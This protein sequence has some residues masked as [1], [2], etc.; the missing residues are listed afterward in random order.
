MRIFSF[1]KLHTLQWVI[2]NPF[3]CFYAKLFRVNKSMPI[4]VAHYMS[5]GNMRDRQTTPR[6]WDINLQ[7]YDG[8]NQTV[9]P[10]ICFWKENYW[11]VCTPYP[12]G[13]DTY[14]NP[15]IYQSVDAINWDIPVGCTNPL[16]FPDLNNKGS[17]ISDPCLISTN[18]ELRV[19]FRDTLNEKGKIAQYIKMVSS[20]DG[21]V[22]SDP[23]VVMQ[24]EIDS[25]I[26][27][28]IMK[29]DKY[30]YMVHIRLDNPYGGT[31]IL[32]SSCDGI[33]WGNEREVQVDNIPHGMFIWH[34]A[35]MT[36]DKYDKNIS[37]NEDNITTNEADN[38]VY[39]VCGN[40]IGLFLL[41]K[42]NTSNV[43]KLFMATSK[44]TG[45]K[46]TI[47]HEIV[48]PDKLREQID[49]FYKAAVIPERGD[50]ILSS[51]DFKGRWY[52]YNIK[53]NETNLEDF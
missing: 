44:D 40:L 11:L 51:R 15:C 30:L 18:D 37:L 52:M 4:I 29:S 1:E 49:I 5:K 7:T 48:I 20:N 21:S 23:Q 10:D 6:N 47:N 17:H 19:Y 8:S 32:S 53:K 2:K 24:S 43:Y 16:A 3:R 31:L 9:H 27:P 39:G 22:W 33:S 38:L 45:L 12:Y 34:I 35:I 14:E 50:I 28:A 41:R 46:W 36:K 26:S 42:L 25:L 13:I